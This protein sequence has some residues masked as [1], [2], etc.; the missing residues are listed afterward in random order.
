MNHTLAA[1]QCW[2]RSC[3][4]VDVSHLFTFPSCHT[5]PTVNVWHVHMEKTHVNTPSPRSL[6]AATRRQSKNFFSYPDTLSSWWSSRNEK[7]QRRVLFMYFPPL[8]VHQHRTMTSQLKQN[9]R[10]VLYSSCYH[11]NVITPDLFRYT[12]II[13]SSRQ[14]SVVSCSDQSGF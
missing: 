4:Q 12:L 3:E 7:Q 8:I 6:N 2:S 10:A 11:C 5:G 1:V 9:K 14:I 13:S